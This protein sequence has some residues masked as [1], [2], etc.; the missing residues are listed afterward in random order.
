MPFCSPSAR[1]HQAETHA[2]L[3]DLAIFL[4]EF[5]FG[6]AFVFCRLAFALELGFDLFPDAF[7]LALDHC[8]RQVE[9]MHAVERIQNAPLHV[10]TAGARKVGLQLFAHPLLQGSEIVEAHLLG[11][12]VVDRDRDRASSLPSP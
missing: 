6:L 10:Q 8:R 5:V 4:L 12:F 1:Q 7:E 9:R 2:A 11:E 3:G